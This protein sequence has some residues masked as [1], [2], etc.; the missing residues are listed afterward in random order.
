MYLRVLNSLKAIKAKISIQSLHGSRYAGLDIDHGRCVRK[1]RSLVPVLF[2]ISMWMSGTKLIFWANLPTTF[3]NPVWKLRFTQFGWPPTCTFCSVSWKGIQGR[4]CDKECHVLGEAPET[5]ALRL[6]R[7]LRLW[8]HRLH[9]PF[10][11]QRSLLPNRENHT[12]SSIFGKCWSNGFRLCS[13]S[14]LELSPHVF[15]WW[16]DTNGYLKVAKDMPRLVVS[17]SLTCWA[18][19]RIFFARHCAILVKLVTINKRYIP[20]SKRLPWLCMQHSKKTG[21]F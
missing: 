15:N 11:E 4:W 2:R 20:I 5:T 13:R 9:L 6:L 8:L 14:H 16:S 19:H 1:D 18:S 7:Y 17:L 10:S 21:T 12:L 3:A